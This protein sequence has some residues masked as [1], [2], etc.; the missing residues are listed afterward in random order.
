M[1]R[2]CVANYT[3]VVPV[4]DGSGYAPRDFVDKP[5]SKLVV[6]KKRRPLARRG[7][8]GNEKRKSQHNG[9]N[10]ENAIF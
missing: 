9:E 5:S 8:R 10:A 3:T 2:P 1:V 4:R 7:G 6:L